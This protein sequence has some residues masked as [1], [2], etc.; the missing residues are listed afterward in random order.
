MGKSEKNKLSFEAQWQGAFLNEKMVVPEG[1]WTKIESALNQQQVIVYKRKAVVYQWAASI[2]IFIA[3]GIGIFTFFNPNN[4]KTN[5]TFQTLSKNS[6]KDSV[7]VRSIDS[8]SSIS[9]N[10]NNLP[11]T[12]K[13]T[14][15]NLT[16]KLAVPT[17]SLINDKDEESHIAMESEQDQPTTRSLVLSLEKEMATRRGIPKL[18]NKPFYV[19]EPPT[20]SFVYKKINIGRLS[21]KYWA[22]VG[23]GTSTFNPNYQQNNAN[24]LANSF[25]AESRTNFINTSA[26]R[27][28]S[29]PVSSENMSSGIQFQAGFN[30]GMRLTPRITLEGGLR[31]S[32]MQVFSETNLTVDNRYFEKTVAITG[33][34]ATIKPLNDLAESDELVKYSFEEASLRNQFR[35]ASLPIKAGYI[36]LDKKFS[37]RI[38]AG[39][40][41]NFYLGNTLSDKKEEFATVNLSPGTESPYRNISFSGLTSLAF[42]YQ[43]FN[44]IELIMEPNYSMALQSMTKSSS[45][46]EALPTTLGVNAGIRYHF[47]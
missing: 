41:T 33:D 25:L 16:P 36:L 13:I 2:A 47:R 40:L 38:N 5:L 42:G 18:W 1:V 46:F 39:F 24:V 44:Q 43:L 4:Q 20:P 32:Q 27:E 7:I 3:A 45:H 29:N 11:K 19:P 23:L 26:N 15:L 21:E 6:L 17:T 35:F 31:Y 8:V 30:L 9:L 14:S 10:E 28:L 22:G 12:E 34:A 37:V